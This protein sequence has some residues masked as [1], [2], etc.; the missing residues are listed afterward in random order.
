M[1][2]RQ[3]QLRDT[4]LT[5]SWNFGANHL[6]IRPSDETIKG[7]TAEGRSEHDSLLVKLSFGHGRDLSGGR[8]YVIETVLRRIGNIARADAYFH[9]T[10]PGPTPKK[11][12][13]R[14]WLPS[15]MFVVSP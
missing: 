1:A 10:G 5:R 3:A 12:R 6:Q 15:G 7:M 2:P 13:Q 11:I 9:R 4:L 8:F 14:L